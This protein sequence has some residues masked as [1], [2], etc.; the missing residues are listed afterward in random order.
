[1]DNKA[2]IVDYIVECME[3]IPRVAVIQRVQTKHRLDL[4]EFWAIKKGSRI[5]EIGCGQGDT[6]AVLAYLVGE[7]GL[8]YGVDIAP[9]GY[10]SPFTVGDSAA[11]LKKSS[12]GKQISMNFDFDVLAPQVNFPDGHFDI[13][14][15]SHSSW[16]LKSPEELLNL[17]SKIRSWGK[18]LCFAEWDTRLKTVEQFPHFLA[19]SIQGQYECFKE[20]SLSNIRTLFNPGDLR[21][22]T[23]K[24]GWK[25][26]REESIISVDLQDARW[27]I[28]FTLSDY[29]TELDKLAGVPHKLKAYIQS[30]AQLLREISQ[31]KSNLQALSTFIF[32]AESS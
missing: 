30:E 22:F 16:Y 18:Y 4:A 8:V 11:Q 29:M 13:I 21:E 3:L 10:G 32:V 9:P 14:V 5:L 24:A 20:T 26:T 6:T 27:E 15:F 17:L 31:N 25:I 1:M 23:A 28:D 7:E 2:E 12:L 19:A